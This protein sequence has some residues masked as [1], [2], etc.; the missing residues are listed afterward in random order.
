[1]MCVS[2][3]VDLGIPDL[4]NVRV[5]GEKS[6]RSSEIATPIPICTK[7]RRCKSWRIFYHARSIVVTNKND[8]DLPLGTWFSMKCL[9]CKEATVRCA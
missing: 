2:R 3:F 6:Q 1:M 9:Q 8:I 5:Y 7:Y 4:D